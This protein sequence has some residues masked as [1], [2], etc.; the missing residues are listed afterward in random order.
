MRLLFQGK[1]LKDNIIAQS[2]PLKQGD[3]LIL[4]IT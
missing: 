1:E 2:I 3:Q 4:M